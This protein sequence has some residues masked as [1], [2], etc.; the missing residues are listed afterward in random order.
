[1]ELKYYTPSQGHTSAIGSN[2]TFMELKL[3]NLLT[4]EIAFVSSNRTFMELKLDRKR[5]F[6]SFRFVLIAPLWN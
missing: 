1:M 5:S 2:R 6:R 4:I 3:F